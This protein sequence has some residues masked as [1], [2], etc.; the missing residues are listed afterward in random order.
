MKEKKKKKKK[1]VAFK[2]FEEV[3]NQFPEVKRAAGE[4]TEEERIEILDALNTPDDEIE[5]EM[6][7]NPSPGSQFIGPK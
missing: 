3:M 1:R 7:P 2:T 6:P 5:L 4:L